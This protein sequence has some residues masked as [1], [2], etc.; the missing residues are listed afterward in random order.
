MRSPPV[1]HA[2]IR[3]LSQNPD[4]PPGFGL[5]QSSGAFQRTAA[6]LRNQGDSR[7]TTQNQRAHSI[8]TSLIIA[9]RI[10]TGF[11]HSARGWLPSGPSGAYP[12]LRVQTISATLKVVASSEILTLA[13]ADAPP[14]LDHRFQPNT[15]RQ[16]N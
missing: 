2:G 7:S 10:P 13:N 1:A 14:A 11:C 8:Q 6:V 4:T 3:S 9:P 5:R 12:G 16:T 15:I